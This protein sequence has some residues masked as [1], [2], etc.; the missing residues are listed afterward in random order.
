MNKKLRKVL[1]FVM[2]A[3]LVAVSVVSASAAT[4]SDIVAAAQENIPSAY[5]PI[6]VNTLESALSRI[7]ATSEQ[8]DKVIAVIKSVRAQVPTDKGSSLHNYTDAE[9]A[10]MVNGFKE[11]L[12][13]LNLRYEIK[14]KNSDVANHTSDE[15]LYIYSKTDDSWVAT[16]DGDA[17][18]GK[19]GT[20]AATSITDKDGNKLVAIVDGDII[21]KTDVD[22]DMS[23]QMILLIV[24]SAALVIASAVFVVCKKLSLK[25]ED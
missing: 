13:I 11:V 6:Y 23:T 17:S 5:S 14:T 2:M 10:A 4:K 24:A 25:N 9:R 22:S 8:C 12:S 1:A 15:V 18:D 20:I 16:A 7:T 19:G 21:K 3:A